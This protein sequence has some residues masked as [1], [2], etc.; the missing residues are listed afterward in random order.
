[1]GELWPWCAVAGLGALHGLSPAGG[2]PL[3]AACG[4]HA[5]L[6]LAAGHLI[7]VALVAGL[8]ALDPAI[9]RRVPLLAAGALLGVTFL[10]HRHGRGRLAAPAG[11]A[12]WSFIGATAHG[13][14]L[15]LVPV[16]VPL[17]VSD[18]PARA[19]TASGSPALALAA[20]GV[21]LGALL[22]ITALLAGAARRVTSAF[23]CALQ[24]R[25]PRPRT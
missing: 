5:L 24:A 14:G 22:G 9:D 12:L 18:G 6:P 2:W 4:R 21:H 15:M 16:L 23:R 3:A 10:L 20:V 8:F 17:C 13:A 19:L 7:S 11:L 1:M 25:R